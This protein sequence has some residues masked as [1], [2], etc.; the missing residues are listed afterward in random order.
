MALKTFHNVE[1]GIRRLVFMYDDIPEIQDIQGRAR[2]RREAT[3]KHQLLYKEYLEDLP[4]AYR[5]ASEWWDECVEAQINQGLGEADAVD[6]AFD[7]RLAGP[8]SSLE[9]V[10]FIRYHWLRFAALNL[11]LDR[12]ER[13]PAQ[14]AML[15]WL[16]D[17]DLRD[18]VQLLTCMPYWPIGLDENGNWC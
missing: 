3:K 11:E 17:D 12:A 16:V 14:T 8:M 1:K 15:S 7:L 2:P 10:W 6:A 5:I 9:V 13:V 18:Y 4:E